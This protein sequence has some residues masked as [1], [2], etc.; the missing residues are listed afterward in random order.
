MTSS[1]LS[2]A[3]PAL[4]APPPLPQVLVV[5]A[6]PQH[7]EL[8][9]QVLGEL[10]QLGRAHTGEQALA[11]AWQQQPDLI[12]V[13]PH[14]PGSMD[15]F[16][17]C[18]H[19]HNDPRS[20][21]IAVVFLGDA[22]E[23]FAEELALNLGA[24]DFIAMPYRAPVLKAR[25]RNQLT[26]AQQRRAMERLSQT[27][28]LTGIA[29]RR[30]FNTALSREFLRLQRL[31]QPLALVVLDMDLFKPFN[32]RYGYL[33]GDDALV[34]VAQTFHGVLQR[35]GDLAARYGGEEF[36]GLLPHTALEGAVQVAQH[37]AQAIAA[38]QIPHAGSDIAPLLTVSMGV[39]CVTPST[40]LSPQK[41]LGTAD[42]RLY[43]AKHGGGNR[44]VSSDD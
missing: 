9:G 36:V 6:S 43:R 14:L 30:Y 8:L 2:S 11:M 32:Q 16:E 40:E 25:V 7:Q 42:H 27:D 35:P 15:G 24:V 23:E 3:P 19:L 26:L 39:A 13:T 31:Q 1:L 37:V 33:A 5:D 21:H 10:C 22:Q 12:L 41:L 28:G 38:L 18:R 17:V 29:N 20:R 44:I 4:Q 34:Q